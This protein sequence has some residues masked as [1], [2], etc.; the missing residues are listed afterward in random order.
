MVDKPSIS[1]LFWFVNHFYKK[2][3]NILVDEPK[4]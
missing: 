2:Y 1:V 3:I 4:K